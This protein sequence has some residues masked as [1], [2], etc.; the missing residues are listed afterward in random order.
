VKGIDI[1]KGVFPFLTIEIDTI[2]VE[3]V[4]WLFNEPGRPRGESEERAIE[5]DELYYANAVDSG[6]KKLQ[7]PGCPKI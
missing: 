7:A 4:F 5:G 1:P 3:M 2:D 6:S